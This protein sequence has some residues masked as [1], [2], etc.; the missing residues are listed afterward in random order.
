MINIIGP[1]Q[2]VRESYETEA[3][4]LLLQHDGEIRVTG[5]AGNLAGLIALVGGLT[6]KL[7]GK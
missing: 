3:Y 7:R 2:V 1:D 6:A 4:L 5:S